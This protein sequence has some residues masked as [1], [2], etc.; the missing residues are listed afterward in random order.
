MKLPELEAVVASRR[1]GAVLRNLGTAPVPPP[2]AELAATLPEIFSG[3]DSD[4]LERVARRLGAEPGSVP[5][6]ELLLLS[7][8]RVHVIKPLIGLGE[9]A[10]LSSTPAGPSL[11]LILAQV[12]ARAAALEEEGE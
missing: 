6:A 3:A 1:T 5:S 7:T 11:G 12:H 9:Q 10:L 4:C 8:S 2:L